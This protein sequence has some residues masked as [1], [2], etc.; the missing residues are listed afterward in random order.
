MFSASAAIVRRAASSYSSKI[1]PSS[2]Y[3][4]RIAASYQTPLFY[5][6]PVSISP[7]LSSLLSSL[8]SIKSSLSKRAAQALN[9]HYDPKSPSQSDTATESTKSTGTT[10]PP[11]DN[12]AAT[13]PVTPPSTPKKSLYTNPNK[14]HTFSSCIVVV[15]VGSAGGN[16]VNN[17]IA[18]SLTFEALL[19]L[20]VG[21]TRIATC[22]V[23]SFLSL[24]IV[25]RFGFVLDWKPF[26]AWV[27]FIFG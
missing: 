21:D 25:R 19:L 17:M 12:E 9:K 11:L 14:L 8:S 24:A 20:F 4:I 7:F 6:A 1:L 22:S 3:G 13:T 18:R 27:C 16:D 23:M 26:Y 15:G 2:S 5:N 10:P